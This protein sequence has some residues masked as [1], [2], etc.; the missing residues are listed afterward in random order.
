MTILPLLLVAALTNMSI[1][2]LSFQKAKGQDKNVHSIS[3]VIV[4][5]CHQPTLA[6]VSPKSWVLIG[7]Q[8]L[9]PRARFRQITVPLKMAFMST[10]PSQRL[11]SAKSACGR[12]LILCGYF[13]LKKFSLL[14]QEATLHCVIQ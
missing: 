8:C 10:F 6:L 14:F 3:T 13:F 4:A 5:C 7:M 2:R 9:L 1:I 11:N 12:Y